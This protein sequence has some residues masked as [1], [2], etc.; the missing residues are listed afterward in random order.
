MF[1]TVPRILFCFLFILSG[2]FLPGTLHAQQPWYYTNNDENGLPSNEVYQVAQD[3]FGYIWI[4]CDAGL[5]R[6]DGFTYKAYISSGQNGRSI[7]SL[8]F[9]AKK[10]LWCKNFN[11]Q[12][13]RVENDSLRIICDLTGKVS[14][15]F[16]F[17]LDQKCNLYA[18]VANQ[19]VM[20]NEDGDS[21]RSYRSKDGAEELPAIFDLVYHHDTI[22]YFQQESGLCWL[23]PRNGEVNTMEMNDADKKFIE[24][25]SFF[26]LKNELHFLAVNYAGHELACGRIHGKTIRLYK[27]VAF[28]NPNIRIHAVC[29]DNRSATWLCTSEGAVLFD[30]Q[31]PEINAANTIHGGEKVSWILNDQEGNYW[32]A[33]LNKGIFVL[34]YLD[35]ILMSPANS[36]LPEKEL[37]A[38]CFTK[39]HE[40]FTGSYSGELYRVNEETKTV[41][42]SPEKRYTTV[43]KIRESENFFLVSRGITEIIE[44]K[45]GKEYRTPFN[46]AR[47][48][49]AVNDTLFFLMPDA[50][51]KT[52]ISGVLKSETDAPKT[53]L[54]KTGGRSMSYNSA[55]QNLYI[56]FNDGVYAYAQGR[57]TGIVHKGKNIYASMLA[58]GNGITWA[59]SLTDGIIGIQNGKVVRQ[60]SAANGIF[61]NNI[62]TLYVNGDT[63]LA[64]TDDKLYVID[65]KTQKIKWYDN[66]SGINPKDI[67]TIEMDSGEIWLA[68]HKGLMHFPFS[69]PAD[70]P[71]APQI[72]ITGANLN[73]EALGIRDLYEL[74]YNN[75]QFSIQISS[76]CFR[77]RGHF[78]YEYQLA[79]LD[80]SWHQVPGITGNVTFTGLPPGDYVFTVRAVNEYGLRSEKSAS[81]QISVRAPAWQQWW[82]YLAVSVLAITIV[83]I[84]YRLRLRA[85]QNRAE[86]KNRITLSQLTALKA[87]MNPHFMYNALNSIQDLVIQH[88]V[89]NSTLYLSKFS[90]LMRKVLDASGTEF[91][92]LQ[93][94]IDILSLYLDLEKLRFGDSFQ[95]QIILRENVQPD[96]IR[97]PSMILQPFV[98]NA[99]KHG[100]LHKKGL[101]KLDIDFAFDSVLICTI[102]DNG[103][104]RKKTAEIKKRHAEKYASFATQA[105]EKR[106]ELLT[107]QTGQKYAFEIIDL[108]ENGIPAGTKV[109]VRIPV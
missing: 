109:I 96:E 32:M 107:S 60:Y 68:T 27:K 80:T 92:S 46:N 4:G 33:T 61:E 73:N 10:R 1:R 102:T 67:S 55:D 26:L 51:G 39:N 54:K 17:T 43:K 42:T 41:F 78:V 59:A 8:R 95:S 71:L 103:V 40:L 57:F 3:D 5:F 7:S 83:V 104:G 28:Q 24:S 85:L 21:I 62:R 22:Y 87:Q 25:A 15:G 56:A 82:F 76:T 19:I 69:L 36:F 86:L 23:N 9:D 53:I 98:E 70:N 38:L 45:S 30:P 100:L 91:I 20:Y 90:Q 63:L 74:P 106:I 2:L 48:L 64:C 75:N 77:S 35:V 12:I 52:T 72:R 34:P 108:E 88:D 66:T 97:M 65:T 89:K 16:P 93:D 6:Y 79:G 84:L 11:G 99:I 101:R 31:H 81:V 14:S 18:A 58:T 49:L 29:S 13:F 50:F 94:E 44:K 37:T 105:T 47:D